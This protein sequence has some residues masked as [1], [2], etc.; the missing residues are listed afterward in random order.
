[1]K[2]AI[3]TGATGMVGM[4]VAK[5]LAS[6]GVNTIALG[7]NLSKIDPA[8][9][10]FSTKLKYFEISMEEIHNLENSIE[11]ISWSTEDCV[12]FNF[13][14]RGN[15][16]ISDGTLNEQMKNVL[17]TANAVNIAKKIGCTKFVNCGSLQE[18]FA[19]KVILG[20]RLNEKPSQMNYTIAKITSRDIA[21]IESYRNKLNYVHTRISVPLSLDLNKESYIQLCLKKILNGAP[22]SEPINTSIFDFIRLEEVA[23]AYF[24]VGKSGVNKADYYIGSKTPSTLSH[25][26]SNFKKYIQKEQLSPYERLDESQLKLFSTSQIEIDTKFVPS[27]SFSI[28]MNEAVNKWRK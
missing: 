25:Y 26:F 7:G 10:N 21:L 12:F 20:S 16:N 19:E 28:F 2:S 18:T 4:S 8:M 22:I 6:K 23:H 15:K 9:F 3:V 11:Q 1:M 13:A 17:H 27:E 24:L 14:W 5:Y